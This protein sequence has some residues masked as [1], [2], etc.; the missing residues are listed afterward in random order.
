MS[1]LAGELGECRQRGLDRLDVDTPP[2]SPISAGQLEQLA[3]SYCARAA[4]QLHGRIAC[5]K[6][7]LHDGLAA[8]GTRGNQADADLITT[9]FFG[10]PSTPGTSSAGEL[11]KQAMTKRGITDEKKF[12]QERRRAFFK[13]AE[14]LILFAEESPPRARLRAPVVAALGLAAL[15]AAGVIFWLSTGGSDADTPTGTPKPA[16]A[17]GT[18]TA[19]SPVQTTVSSPPFRPGATYTQTVN[20]TEGANTYT[21]P[22]NLVGLG[23]RVDDGTS[24]QVSCKI[25]APGV[26]SVGL[27]WYRIADPPWSDRYYSPANSWLNGDP[28]GGPYT[29]VVDETVP[30]CPP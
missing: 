10:D 22:Y 18:N 16:A 21:D 26:R 29:R 5:I 13:F 27:Y 11:L 28:I 7:L 20:T 23:P 1:Q 8:Y 24:V 3:R 6:Q 9:L 15:I 12:R 30:Y 19:T 25:V 4:P 14:F 17:S 2:Q